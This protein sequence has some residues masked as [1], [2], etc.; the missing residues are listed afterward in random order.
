MRPQRLSLW[1]L[2]LLGTT[3]LLML[4]KGTTALAQGKQEKALYERL[5]GL[6]PIASIVDEFFDLIWVNDVLNANP[7]TK[8]ARDQVPMPGLKFHVTSLI[9]KVT[10]GP[11]N[12][13]GRTIK[14]AHSL[15]NIKEREWQALL[16]DFRRVLN[17]YE[18]PQREQKELIAIMVSL[19]K[20]IVG[21]AGQ[22]K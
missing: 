1:T 5:G 2:V 6:Y 4:G 11:C 22:K 18:V 17:S 21:P 10:G 9:C 14:E 13:T 12:Y 20:D 8:A 19:K 16:A 15:L 3:V 7:E